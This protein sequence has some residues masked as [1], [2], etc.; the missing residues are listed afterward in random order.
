M[1]EVSGRFHQ[2]YEVPFRVLG[3]QAV[4]IDPRRREVHRLNETGTRIWELLK[5]PLTV[6]ELV[7]CLEPEYAADKAALQTEIQ[8]FIDALTTMGLVV[9]NETT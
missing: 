5:L 4:L 2:D 3:G 9:R 8:G 7:A 6:P 1:Q